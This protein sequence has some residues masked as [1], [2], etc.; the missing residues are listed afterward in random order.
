MESIS[1]IP[2]AEKFLASLLGAYISYHYERGGATTLRHSIDEPLLI[3]LWRH[4]IQQ[5]TVIG[6][7]V[8]EPQTLV[9]MPVVVVPWLLYHHDNCDSRYQKLTKMLTAVDS[10]S[11]AL[12]HAVGAVCIFGDCLEWL[13]QCSLAVHQPLSSICSYLIKRHVDSRTAFASQVEKFIEVLE[14]Q[15]AT[16]IP[17]QLAEQPL[18]TAALAIKHCLSCR[19]NL[20]LSLANS[21]RT[22]TVAALCGCLLG[23]WGGLSVIPKKWVVDLA[24][25]FHQPINHLADKL[26]RSWAGIIGAPDTCNASPLSFLD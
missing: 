25:D 14:P 2:T 26:Y 16:K 7:S 6:R 8:L 1:T 12:T 18:L 4:S 17:L 23:A 24:N 21:Q 5:P 3:Q 15:I 10:S 11:A 19:E 22:R 9:S 20:A 13:M